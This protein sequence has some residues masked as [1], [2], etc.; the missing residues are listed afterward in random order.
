MIVVNVAVDIDPEHLPAM[1]EGIVFG[2]AGAMVLKNN[3]IHTL[4]RGKESP[5]VAS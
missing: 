5:L 2:A 1:K 3:S 4:R